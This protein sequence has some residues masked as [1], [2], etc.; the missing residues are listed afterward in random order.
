MRMRGKRKSGRAAERQSGMLRTNRARLKI[1][2]KVLFEIVAF[3]V[4]RG[5]NILFEH[6][7]HNGNHDADEGGAEERQSGMLRTNRARLKILR[8][9]FFEIVALKVGRG[10]G[11]IL[12]EHGSQISLSVTSIKT[13][14]RWVGSA[15]NS[16]HGVRAVMGRKRRVV[17]SLLFDHC[18]SLLT[19]AQQLGINLDVDE[20]RFK[21]RT[22]FDTI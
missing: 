2:R 20:E 7:S 17:I 3:K 22:V 6:G 8:K 12:F 9:V 1:L 14:L 10:G 16:S 19:R 5:G 15:D 11:K 13:T 4:G 21:K 18:S